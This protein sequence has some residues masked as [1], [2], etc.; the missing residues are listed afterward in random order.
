MPRVSA[1]DLHWVEPSLVVEVE[2]AEWTTDGR[3]RAPVYLGLRDDRVPESVV[4]EA[5]VPECP[6][7]SAAGGGR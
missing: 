1:R 3:L 5:Q 6:R 2:F 7:F 4:R